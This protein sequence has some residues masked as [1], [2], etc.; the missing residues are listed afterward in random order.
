MNNELRRTWKEAIMACFQILSQLF[1]GETE[2]N[3]DNQDSQCP[4]EDS[5]PNINEK[6]CHL[7]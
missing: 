2:E 4:G 1:P 7:T 5:T 3:H 6:S